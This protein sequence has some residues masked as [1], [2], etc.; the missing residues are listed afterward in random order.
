MHCSR[1]G[2]K[3][4]FKKEEKKSHPGLGEGASRGDDGINETQKS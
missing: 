4:I 1:V 3:R 2:R